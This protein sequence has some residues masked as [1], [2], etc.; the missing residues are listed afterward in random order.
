M[1]NCVNINKKITLFT[2]FGSKPEQ[3][4]G[5]RK[6]IE[7]RKIK[8]SKLTKHSHGLCSLSICLRNAPQSASKRSFTHGLHFLNEA[9]KNGKSE[10]LSLDAREERK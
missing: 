9:N 2:C 4:K 10:N 6:S 1:G 3:V 5:S 7:D 8:S